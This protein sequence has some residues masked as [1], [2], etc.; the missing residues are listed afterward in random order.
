VHLIGGAAGPLRGDDLRLD[1]EVRPHAR[2]DIRSV[3]A[4][5]LLPGRPAPP[6]RLVIRA[7]VGEG[8]TLRWTP[9]PTIAAA[10]CDHHAITEVEVAEG[11]ILLWRDDVVCGRHGEPSGTIRTETTVRYAGRT[12]YR[13]DLTLGEG[14]WDGA[15]VLGENR[16]L[17]AAILVGS[18]LVGSVLPGPHLPG[19]DAAVMSLAGPGVLATA[20][21]ADIRAVKAALDPICEAFATYPPPTES[22]QAEP[23]PV[24]P[25]SMASAATTE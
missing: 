22:E 21:G 19:P 7:Q 8:A 6:S 15:A 11:G 20:A 3:A 1:V 5:L 2:L 14:A 12:L 24:A 25:A 17:G 4:T 23:Q 18:V 13:H 16:A 10:R 9:E